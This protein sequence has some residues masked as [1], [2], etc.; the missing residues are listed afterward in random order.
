MTEPLRE[1]IR[2]RSLRVKT[3]GAIARPGANWVGTFV[4]GGIAVE[5]VE[6]AFTVFCGGKQ[7]RRLAL[8]RV[9]RRGNGV[10]ETGQG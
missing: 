1:S 3:F 6:M 8:G 7:S 2:R 9:G 10:D 4:V 5:G